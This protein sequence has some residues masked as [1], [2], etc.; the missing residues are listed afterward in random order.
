MSTVDFYKNIVPVTDMYSLIRSDKFTPVPEDWDIIVTDIYKS[1][2]AIQQGRYKDVNFVAASTIIAVLNAM[3]DVEIPFV[4]GGDGATLLI[5]SSFRLKICDVLIDVKNT[6]QKQFDL[7]LRTGLVPVKILYEN[8]VTVFVAKHSI[9]EN[10]EQAIFKGGGLSFAEDLVKR[11]SE[12]FK[13]NTEL[14]EGCANF[15]GLE[16]R[17]QDI[18]SFKGES[19]SLIVKLIEEENEPDNYNTVL[20]E[21]DHLYGPAAKRNPISEENI[22]LTFKKRGP[23]YEAKI[24]GKSKLFHTIRVWLANLYANYLFKYGN[25][26]WL[27]Y[28]QLVKSTCDYEKFDDTLKVVLS[29]SPYQREQL[30]KILDRYEQEKKIVYGVLITDRALITCL[31]FERHGRQVHFVDAADGGYAL[32]SKQLKEKLE[33]LKSKSSV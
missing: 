17:W 11:G 12:K 6:V 28:K 23:A 5:P 7:V 8:G 15:T 33:K 30:L 25:E 18:Y 2:E 32:A 13:I 1:T 20:K 9:S 27:R 19:M 31:I 29:G 14:K 22:K 4:F 21:I 10:Y 16:C 26:E 3:T 24:Q